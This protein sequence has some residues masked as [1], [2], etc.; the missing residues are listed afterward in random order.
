MV[1]V[2][3]VLVNILDVVLTLAS[4]VISVYVSTIFTD[5]RTKPDQRM[6]GDI[7]LT[8]DAIL[9][10][11]VR[12]LVLQKVLKFFGLRELTGSKIILNVHILLHDFGPRGRAAYLHRLSSTRRTQ[13][14]F[15]ICRSFVSLSSI[16]SNDQ[17]KINND[18]S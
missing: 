18:Q 11:W 2:P 1:I 4:K 17:K 7:L 6:R 9:V 5:E 15:G 10:I 13:N 16:K 12:Q 14:I 8:I 3:V